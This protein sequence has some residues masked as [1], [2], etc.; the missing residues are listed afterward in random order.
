MLETLI[1]ERPVRFRWVLGDERYGRDTTLLDR[2]D[3][4]GARYCMEVPV[5]TEVWRELPLTEIPAWSG[6]GRPPCKERLVE[7]APEPER[8]DVIAASLP[9]EQWQPYRIKEGAKGPI[10][11]EFAFLRVVNVREKLP[12]SEVWLILRRTRKEV[13]V[14][15]SNAPAE[16]PV[17]ELVRVTGMRWPIE[18]CFEE[19]KEELGMDHYEV[20]SWTGWHH[21]M[22][23]TMLAHH[24]LVHVRQ[25]L[26]GKSPGLTVSQAKLLLQTALPRKHLTIEE[27][28]ALILDI[29]ARNHRAYCSHRSGV[30]QRLFL[31]FR[32]STKP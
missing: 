17:E 15:L 31:K 21:H 2:R 9:P 22:T 16:V 25:E 8:A 11:A 6:R 12:G 18:T 5:S 30:N 26:R 27:A 10:V 1:R 23:L 20:R 29:Q 7:G 4:A 3:A 32:C 19:C 13:Q 28:V 24:F 14:Y